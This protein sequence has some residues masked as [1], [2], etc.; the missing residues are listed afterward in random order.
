M[1]SEK[2]K[3]ETDSALSCRTGRV[4]R[5]GQGFRFQLFTLPL[6]RA[7]PPISRGKGA[8]GYSNVLFNPFKNMI[9]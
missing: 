9:A 8:D 6:R 7:C 1:A 5:R 3:D 4:D 2:T